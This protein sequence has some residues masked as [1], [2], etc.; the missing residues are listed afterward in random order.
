MLNEIKS[1]FKIGSE[2]D[3][4]KFLEITPQT[5]HNWK[6][7]NTF[8]ITV[9]YTKCVNVSAEWLITGE[10]SM[11]KTEK[12]SASVDKKLTTEETSEKADAEYWKNEYIAVQKKYT[13]LL[14]NKLQE[15]FKVDKSSKAG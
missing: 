10:G 12:N 14:E 6:K 11:L 15:V 1:H 9:V 8:D 13:A 2:T 3:F 5:L 4:A 7:R